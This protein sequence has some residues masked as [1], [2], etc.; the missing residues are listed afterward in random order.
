VAAQS[1]LRLEL[2][3]GPQAPVA[4]RTRERAARPHDRRTISYLSDG[5]HFENPAST[6]WCRAARASS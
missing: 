5:G 1:A 2:D 3:A 4:Q 6:S